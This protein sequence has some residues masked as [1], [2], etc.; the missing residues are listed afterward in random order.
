MRGDEVLENLRQKNTNL[1]VLILSGESEVEKR[2]TCLQLGADDYL[3]KPFNLRELTARL[4][5]LARRANGHAQN[6]LIFGDV[7]LD[8]NARDVRVGNTRVDLTAKEYQMFELLCLRKGNVVSKESFL[9]HL[10]GGMDEPE[11]KIIDVFICKLRK[12]IEAAGAKDEVIQTVWG[13][14]YRV[15]AQPL[16]CST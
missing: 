2:L 7:T 12:K 8:L 5:A 11:M 4:Y 13:R 15:D 10:Y 14:G 6:Q 3:L 16:A 1:P 9:D